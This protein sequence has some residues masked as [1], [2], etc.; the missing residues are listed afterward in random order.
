MAKINLELNRA[1]ENLV[2]FALQLGFSVSVFYDDTDK[3][4]KTTNS[5]AIF[6]A[7]YASNDFELHFYDQNSSKG[8]AWIIINPPE[9]GTEVSDYSGNAPWIDEWSDKYMEI[10]DS[11]GER[12]N[13]DNLPMW[14]KKPMVFNYEELKEMYGLI[15]I[16]ECNAGGRTLRK[17]SKNSWTEENVKHNQEAYKLLTKLK[18]KFESFGFGKEN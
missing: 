4:E 8:F 12:I 1:G 5:K 18:E 10:F 2:D 11:Y 17:V 15:C 9:L 3:L 13:P 6:E 7:M 16:E 14:A